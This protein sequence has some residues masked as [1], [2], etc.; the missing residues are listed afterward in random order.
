MH[1]QKYMRKTTYLYMRI[2]TRCGIGLP[3]DVTWYCI[4]Q[5]PVFVHAIYTKCGIGL[6][7]E[8]EQEKYFI[9]YVCKG[10]QEWHWPP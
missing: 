1:D 6:P 10:S 9:F 2:Y 3:G 7:G 8:R 4:A 5:P